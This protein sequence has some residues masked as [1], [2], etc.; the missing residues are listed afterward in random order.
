[1]FW[2]ILDL[3]C[4]YHLC[5]CLFSGIP[6]EKPIYVPPA[7]KGPVILGEVRNP[8]AETRRIMLKQ[9]MEEHKSGS[10]SSSPLRASN[11]SSGAESGRSASPFR[12]SGV[13]SSIQSKQ[14]QA[15]AH[16][17]QQHQAEIEYSNNNID[18]NSP[19]KPKV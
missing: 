8:E 11:T 9:K 6:I 4:L 15:E 19:L 5:H 13:V 17:Q 16:Q 1:M 2:M 12:P 7:N 3:L 10:R 18:S 14:G